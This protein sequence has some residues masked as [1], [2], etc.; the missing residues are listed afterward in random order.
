[1]LI[2]CLVIYIYILCGFFG[3]V[4][5]VGASQADTGHCE[6]VPPSQAALCVP[7]VPGVV[8]AGPSCAEGSP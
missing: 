4:I 3:C 8:P 7:E 1:M 6:A 2:F 5:F